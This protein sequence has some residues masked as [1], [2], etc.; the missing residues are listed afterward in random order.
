ME[1]NENI[2][3][4]NINNMVLR[5]IPREHNSNFRHRTGEIW[6]SSM[7]CPGRPGALKSCRRNNLFLSD[8]MFNEEGSNISNQNWMKGID[9]HFLSFTVVGY[10]RECVGNDTEN[11]D[12]EKQTSILSCC[13][14]W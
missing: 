4:S 8:W 11:L 3:I 6:R 9:N 14:F 5:I 12:S 10:G 7:R 1:E 2:F 13:K